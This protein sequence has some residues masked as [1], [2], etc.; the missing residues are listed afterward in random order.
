MGCDNCKMLLTLEKQTNFYR[1]NAWRL[2]KTIAKVFI[3]KIYNSS[4]W[5]ILDAQIHLNLLFIFFENNKFFA[6][7]IDNEI[8]SFTHNKRNKNKCF[9]VFG[10]IK[11][12]STKDITQFDVLYTNTNC[13]NNSKNATQ[14]TKCVDEENNNNLSYAGAKVTN[15]TAIISIK[16]ATFY[17]R[18]K[19]RNSSV[20]KIKF[21][22][23][24][25]G[26]I[27]SI[28]VN[29]RFI[30]VFIL[31][32]G[33][34]L[35]QQPEEPFFFQS[36][37][38]FYVKACCLTYY[39]ML[40]VAKYHTPNN[41]SFIWRKLEFR[42]KYGEPIQAFYTING[43]IYNFLDVSCFR[44][45]ILALAN[46]QILINASFVQNKLKINSL[47]LIHQKITT[48]S[49]TTILHFQSC[50]SSILVI[51]KNNIVTMY[52]RKGRGLFTRKL[53]SYPYGIYC[54]NRNDFL[55]Y[56][57]N[58]HN[59]ITSV[60]LVYENGVVTIVLRL[61]IASNSIQLYY[62]IGYIYIGFKKQLSYTVQQFELHKIFYKTCTATNSNKFHC[63]CPT[64]LSGHHCAKDID[65]CEN[66]P[67][68]KSKNVHCIN[69]YGS[70][71]CVCLQGYKQNVCS[72]FFNFAYK[73]IDYE[74]CNNGSVVWDDHYNQ[75]YVCLCPNNA[76][77]DKNCNLVNVTSLTFNATSWYK[78]NYKVNVRPKFWALPLKLY[79]FSPK[80]ILALFVNKA[81]LFTLQSHKENIE[82]K[83]VY[84]QKRHL[85]WI[86]KFFDVYNKTRH[87]IY[88]KS[89][90]LN[91]I[92]IISQRSMFIV[93]PN[94]FS[95]LKIRK[96]FDF[97]Q[98]QPN[99]CG[100]VT[101]LVEIKGFLYV[102]Y[103]NY[104]TSQKVAFMSYVC[105]LNF[106]LNK[107]LKKFI[108]EPHVKLSIIGYLPELYIVRI[109][110][111]HPQMVFHKAFTFELRLCESFGDYYCVCGFFHNSLNLK[112]G[113]RVEKAFNINNIL[114]VIWTSIASAQKHSIL[115]L[116]RKYGLLYRKNFVRC[117]VNDFFIQYP[118]LF[119]VIR[120]NR[121]FSIH[122]LPFHV[123]T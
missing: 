107:C 53:P 120:T 93:D 78:E 89:R 32:A 104:N 36:Y 4:K 26:E 17:H 39:N 69:T 66:D 1:L 121:G 44:K 55:A 109:K 72:L 45:H 12:F 60:A 84:L 85:Y 74:L 24:T 103:V 118:R 77:Y 116:S 56:F 18:N 14:T 23:N 10:S 68:G 94:N 98:C 86:P 88:Y 29:G 57:T 41:G 5:K 102:S 64:G 51:G 31:N 111:E 115:Y 34:V 58:L 19:P 108:M 110:K 82:T 35:F 91:V 33:F 2:N 52:N 11:C 92:V 76:I 7:I 42:S 13:K 96:Y 21:V 15:L 38:N 100:V 87:A 63:S 30:Y 90:L 27:S 105:V 62:R 113:R 9:L 75:N 40:V 50:F 106:L 3:F 112:V 43:K 47:E 97:L 71:K 61:N 25:Y 70:Y 37:D 79:L 67:C 59:K 6:Y 122:H 65:E 117:E 73:D 119:V 48:L 114:F 99:A 16:L 95:V 83:T 28:V 49:K 20:N 22:D 101:A 80:I 81:I 123:T 46:Q 54:I 8:I